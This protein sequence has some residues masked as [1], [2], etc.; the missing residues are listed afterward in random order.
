MENQKTLSLISSGSRLL[1]RPINNL[2][3]DKFKCTEIFHIQIRVLKN[4]QVDNCLSRLIYSFRNSYILLWHHKAHSKWSCKYSVRVCSVTKLTKMIW[5][6]SHHFWNE[7][8]SSQIFKVYVETS[9]WTANMNQHQASKPSH[10]LL[11]HPLPHCLAAHT[12]E[13]HQAHT[14]CR[15]ACPIPFLL[16]ATEKVCMCMSMCTLCMSIHIGV[17]SV[18]THTLLPL[19]QICMHNQWY[20]WQYISHAGFT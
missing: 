5:L 19:C 7:N 3:M 11:M 9:S 6:R 15:C 20:I 4:C 17:P 14:W 2:R 18:R 1:T 13:S 16:L 12:N 8:Y 10:K